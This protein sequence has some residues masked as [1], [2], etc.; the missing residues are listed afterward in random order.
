MATGG[1][2][3]M[4][5]PQLRDAAASFDCAAATVLHM[6]HPWA[7]SSGALTTADAKVTTARMHQSLLLTRFIGVLNCL[8]LM[9]ERRAS[10]G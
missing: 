3:S 7:K 2:S 10:E 8:T 4:S 5:I 6:A 1:T 9:S